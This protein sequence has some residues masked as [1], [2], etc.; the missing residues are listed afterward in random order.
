MNEPAFESRD[1]FTVVGLAYHGPNEDG[2]IPALWDVFGDRE[3]EFQ[4]LAT[5]PECYGVCTSVDAEDGTVEYVAGVPADED[6]TIPEGMVAVDLP[7]AEYAVFATTLADL[8]GDVDAFYGE[9]L[10]GA[11]YE[12]ADGAEF[13]RYDSGFDGGQDAELEYFVPVAATE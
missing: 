6:A 11:D 13:E 5:A 12:R 10:P 8:G 4:S 9:W 3:G 7:A 2:Q 1:A